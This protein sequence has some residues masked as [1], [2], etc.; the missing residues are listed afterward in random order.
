MLVV[1]KQDYHQVKRS[2]RCPHV[3]YHGNEHVYN[4]WTMIEHR[5]CHQAPES[6]LVESEDDFEDEDEDEESSGVVVDVE[7]DSKDDRDYYSLD[8]D[9][10]DFDEQDEQG[11]ADQ[12]SS[13]SGS[14]YAVSEEVF[15]QN[16]NKANPNIEIDELPRTL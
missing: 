13:D 11:N 10:L 9:D 16:D 8:Y 2:E 12:A 5:L 3:N 15:S 6:S 14:E 1:H 4:L 7:K